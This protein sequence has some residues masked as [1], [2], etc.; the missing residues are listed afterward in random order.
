MELNIFYF[1]FCFPLF[2][3]NFFLLASK[4]KQDCVLCPENYRVFKSCKEPRAPT[5][6]PSLSVA[7]HVEASTA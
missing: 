3:K 7:G 5:L 4:E 1:S 2:L 6:F